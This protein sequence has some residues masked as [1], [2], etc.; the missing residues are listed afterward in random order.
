MLVLSRHIDESIQI[1]DDVTVTILEVKGKQIRI[2]VT[3]PSDVEV[4]REE[5]Y[6]R[7]MREQFTLRKSEIQWGTIGTD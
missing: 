7:V 1:G 5:V 6:V 3:A 4:H 2:G